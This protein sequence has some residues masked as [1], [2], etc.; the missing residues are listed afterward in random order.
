MSLK[1]KHDFDQFDSSSISTTGDAST[2]TSPL[3]TTTIYIKTV[4]LLNRTSSNN[5]FLNNN[6]PPNDHNERK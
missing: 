4:Q 5:I 3:T 6:S 2:P 1:R